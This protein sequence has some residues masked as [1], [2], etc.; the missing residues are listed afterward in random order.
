MITVQAIH[1]APVK[2]LALLDQQQVGVTERGITEDRRFFVIDAA[3]NLVT[4]RQIG[5]LV[6]VQASYS[7]DDDL[8]TLRFPEGAEVSG[9][10]CPGEAV[11]TVIW[12][13]RVGGQVIEGGWGE[14]LSEF[15]GQPVRLVR[16]DASGACYDEY[17]VS[18]MSQATVDFLSGLTDGQMRFDGRRFRPN[19]LLSGGEPHQE[20]GWLGRG[21]RIGD[22]AVLRIVARDP[23]CAITTLDPDTGRRDFDTLRL[24]LGYRPSARAAYLGVYGIVDQPGLVSVGDAVV[25]AS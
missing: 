25:V 10:P 21:L 14:A 19:F 8:L 2:S 16:S 18:V 22:E 23:R 5:A 4:Q 11:R 15:C 17:P 9:E 12:G 13:R 1:V 20:D 24:I 3:G 7:Q 6:Q